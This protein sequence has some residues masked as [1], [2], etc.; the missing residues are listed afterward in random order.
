[1]LLD[2]PPTAFD[3]RFRFL[4]FPVRVSPFFWLGMAL[5]GQ[6]WFQIG[7]EFGLIWVACGFAS[8]LVHEL[9]HALAI[10]RFGSSA[11]IELFAFGGMAIA[12]YASPSAYRRMG[13]AAAGPAAGATLFGIVYGTHLL[14]G[15]GGN[16]AYTSAVYG[17]L[18][19]MNLFWTIF[20]LLPIW[21][22]DGGHI[23]RELFVIR[24][25]RQPDF[26]T[27][28][29]SFV[30]ALVLGI[31]GILM[32]FGSR[33]MTMNLAKSLPEW[34]LYAIPGPVMSLFLL[35]LA[36]Q[37]YEAMKQYRRPHLYSDDDSAPWRSRR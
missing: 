10:R 28:K 1:M 22:F 26:R 35:L 15:W 5:F 9:G 23:L 21:P 34:L 11:R 32:N 2:N 14:T 6:N 17:A 31:F 37:C 12:S 7:I 36:Y 3:L 27:Q 19:M 4:G 20:N 25:V 8:I 16:N 13:I 29:I 33:E 18:F 24:N 30:V